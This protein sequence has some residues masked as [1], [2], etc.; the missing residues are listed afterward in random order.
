MLIEHPLA[1]RAY[2]PRMTALPARILIAV[3]VVV[4]LLAPGLAVTDLLGEPRS[5]A[6]AAGQVPSAGPTDITV[7]PDDSRDRFVGTGGV[8]VDQPSY[9][10]DRVQ[11][12]VCPGCVWRTS[13]ACED[14]GEGDCLEV[15]RGCPMGMRKVRVW[16]TRPGEAERMVGWACIGRRGPVTPDQ[17]QTRVR[18]RFIRRVPPVRPSCQPASAAVVGI[19]VVCASGQPG[20]LAVREFSLA[21]RQV[22]ITVQPRWTWTFEPGRVL[23]TTRPGGPWPDTSVT[24]TFLRPGTRTVAV[25]VT[26]AGSYTIDGAG[27][28]AVSGTVD[29]GSSV[30]V[31]VVGGV[32]HIV[33]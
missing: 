29:Q 18:D 3:P 5:A 19:P 6:V 21:H 13:T 32:T 12:Y 4:G 15:S 23:T 2:R 26:W 7:D 27:P 16:L 31:R 1:F 20:A 28:Y 14:T 33:R 24:H 17:V 8:V 10:T 25:Q 11:S 30:A 22:R 9:G